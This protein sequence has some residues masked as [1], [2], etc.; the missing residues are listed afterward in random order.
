MPRHIF[1]LLIVCLLIPAAPAAEPTT[2]DLPRGPHGGLLREIGHCELGHAEF[3]VS[4]TTIDLWLLGPGHTAPGSVRIAT[5]AI[6]SL[7]VTP[8]GEQM[9]I[10][11]SSQPLALADEKPG[12]CSH[13]VA[14]LETVPISFSLHA[15]CVFRGQ[16]V[17][18]VLHWP[19]EPEPAADAEAADH[20]DPGHSHEEP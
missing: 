19:P 20:H 4:E 14:T 13:F 2:P 5:P 8:Q 12:D 17:P 3:S 16:T 11:L 1:S 7:L 10:V 6:P 15:W 9:A 18:L